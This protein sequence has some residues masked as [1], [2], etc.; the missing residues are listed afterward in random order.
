MM[1]E[2]NNK[3]IMDRMVKWLRETVPGRD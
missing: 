1:L 2:R 3:V